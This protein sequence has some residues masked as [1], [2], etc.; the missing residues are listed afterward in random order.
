VHLRDPCGEFF[1]AAFRRN[2][3]RH[4][5]GGDGV[6]NAHGHVGYV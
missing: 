3:V 4:G 5:L 6:G 2:A 1:A